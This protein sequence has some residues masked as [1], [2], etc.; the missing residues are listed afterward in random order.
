MLLR[1][2]YSN[3]GNCKYGK[4]DGINRRQY[5]PSTVQKW[6]NQY[7]EGGIEALARKA[8]SIGVRHQC[9]VLEERILA[10][11][12]AYPEHGVR[13]IRDDLHRD[14]GA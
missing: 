5:T 1:G 13:R 8:S 6:R 14:E 2:D 10:Q 12:K 3:N 4:A 9:S 7:A 11:R